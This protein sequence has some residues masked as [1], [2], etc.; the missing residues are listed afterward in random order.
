M[1]SINV[2]LGQCDCH[3]GINVGPS[4]GDC[5]L[6]S[7]P[8]KPIPIPCPIPRSVTFTVTLGV[9]SETCRQYMPNGQH[10]ANCP[11]KPI[12]VSC[13]IS[14]ETWAGS[15]VRSIEPERG[16]GAEG[17]HLFAI[18]RARW[19]GVQA[20]VTGQ[21][22]CCAQHMPDHLREQRDAVFA[23]LAD[24]ARLHVAR[25]SAANRAVK[26]AGLDYPYSEALDEDSEPALV[27][28]EYVDRLIRRVGTLT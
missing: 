16:H 7:C 22:G 17:P 5:P 26:A 20:L 14:G 1:S 6:E 2:N 21:H 19:A 15:E 27:L 10:T 28:E 11:G 9:C 18:C 23:A 25:N 8:G 3:A 24:M 13:D 4:K 12:R